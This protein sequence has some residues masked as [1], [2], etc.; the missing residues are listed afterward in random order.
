MRVALSWLRDWV[1]YMGFKLCLEQ[2]LDESTF[3]GERSKW[4]EIQV[5]VDKS[6]W[7]VRRKVGECGVKVTYIGTH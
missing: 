3:R 5:S 7:R 1:V 6:G 4:L 2:I